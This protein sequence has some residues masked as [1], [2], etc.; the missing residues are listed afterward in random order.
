[1]L[2]MDPH[3]KHITAKFRIGVSDLA[4]HR[5]RH[6]EFKESDLICPLCKKEKEDEVHFVLCCTALQTLRSKYIPFKYYRQPCLFRLSLL[7]ASRRDIDVW[8]LSLFLSKAFKVREIVS[9]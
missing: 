4:V 3:L 2:N 5:L 6:R 8:G 9:S 7:M 1:M